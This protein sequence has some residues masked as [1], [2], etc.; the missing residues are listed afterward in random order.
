MSSSAYCRRPPRLLVNRVR[1]GG[2]KKNLQQQ[3]KITSRAAE[4]PEFDPSFREGGETKTTPP[5]LEQPA[6]GTDR[7]EETER[8]ASASSEPRL[9]HADGQKLPSLFA[10]ILSMT[11]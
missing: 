3:I 4:S 7:P 1:D 9:R 11:F 5:G 8:Y 6:G 10:C 2:R